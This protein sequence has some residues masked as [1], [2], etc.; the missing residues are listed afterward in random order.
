MYFSNKQIVVLNKLKNN[1]LNL[2]EVKKERLLMVTL[3]D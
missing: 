1:I 2:L 3:L